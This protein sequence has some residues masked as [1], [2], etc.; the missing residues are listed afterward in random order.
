M[1]HFVGSI[2]KASIQISG[3]NLILCDSAALSFVAGPLL[4]H[5]AGQVNEMSVE[6]SYEELRKVML[7]IGFEI[8]VS[9]CFCHSK[10]ERKSGNLVQQNG[11]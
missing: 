5:W 4:Y 8:E 11:E 3:A 2:K 10:L 7:D 1:I 9:K 6:L